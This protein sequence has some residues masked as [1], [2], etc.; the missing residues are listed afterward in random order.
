[1]KKKNA[2]YFFVGKSSFVDKDTSIFREQFE[3]TTFNFEFG[4]KWR[5]PFQLLQQFVFLLSNIW[6]TDI[7]IIQLS[8]FHGVLPIIFSMLAGKKSVIIAAGTDCHSFPSIGYGNYQKYFLSMATKFCFKNCTHILPK[9]ES[10]WQTNYDY[11][12]SD[13]PQQGLS[14]F[15]PGIKT[16]HTSIPNG[17]SAERFKKS[18]TSQPKSFITISGLLHR[19]SQQK[20]KGIDLIIEA[21]KQLPDCTFTILGASSLDQDLPGNIQLIPATPNDQLNSILSSHQYYMQLSMAEG[22]PNALCEAMLCECIPIGS[23][24]FSIPEIISDTGFILKKRSSAA[25]VELINEIKDKNH[26]EL[27]VKARNRIAENFSLENRKL[28]MLE[29]LSKI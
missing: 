12:N 6:S 11:D 9:H 8:G 25:L 16:P 3:V 20:L 18:G 29:A 1:M 15:V 10:L 7:I 24:V 28:K 17:F 23:N 21:A 13:F 19:T 4:Q 27:G 22:F 5:I 26:P 2:L 14:Y